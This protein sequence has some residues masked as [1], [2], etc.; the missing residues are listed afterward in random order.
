MNKYPFND[1]SDMSPSVSQLDISFEL[2]GFHSKLLLA[3]K[4]VEKIIGAELYKKIN[5]HFFSDNYNQE[6]EAD[7]NFI[8]LNKLVS[9]LQGV[10]ANFAVYRQY[11]WLV[12]KV[13]TE[14]VSQRSGDEYK[15]VTQSMSQEAKN[16][17]LESAWMFFDDLIVALDAEID[18]IPEWKAIRD[19]KPKLQLIKTASEFSR[20]TGLDGNS[21]FFELLYPIL[22]EIEIE[23][24]GS[25]FD[26]EDLSTL[27]DKILY[28]LKKA[29]GYDAIS[30]AIFRFD[31]HLL[32]APIRQDLDTEKT[33][34]SRDKNAEFIKE[35]LKNHFSDK[36]KNY[37]TNASNLYDE[38]T[39]EDSSSEDYE[40]PNSLHYGEEDDPVVYT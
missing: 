12:M 21:F 25:R 6:N 10:I 38:K 4:D 2:D 39:N 11:I 28:N 35:K 14:G 5:E 33:S 40:L 36:A 34:R 30:E 9:L 26:V 29:V 27:G 1:F 13:S 18:N 31:Y 19:D 37:Y 32:P 8:R 7:D 17:L 3:K 15:P 24:V 23:N 22:E 16:D 20:V